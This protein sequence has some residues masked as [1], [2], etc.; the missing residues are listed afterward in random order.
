M[1]KPYKEKERE[2]EGQHLIPIQTMRIRLIHYVSLCILS[3]ENSVI[4]ILARLLMLL[5]CW[6]RRALDAP[7]SNR[8]TI[9]TTDAMID[10]GIHFVGRKSFHQIRKTLNTSH[11][12]PPENAKNLL[13]YAMRSKRYSASLLLHAPNIKYQFATVKS[14]QN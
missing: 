8:H 6:R 10:F 12:H 14:K 9:Q 3:I 1:P 11:H 2:R 13:I 4:M 7:K 5:L